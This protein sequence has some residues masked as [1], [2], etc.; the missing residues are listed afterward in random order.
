MIKYIL[1]KLKLLWIYIKVSLFLEFINRNKL[2]QDLLK[3]NYD[4]VENS[5]YW[6]NDLKNEYL[7]S[8]NILKVSNVI[9]VHKLWDNGYIPVLTNGKYDFD[10]IREKYNDEKTLYISDYN[11]SHFLLSDTDQFYFRIA[12]DLDHIE[13]NIGFGWIN[14]FYIYNEL[15]SKAKKI[16]NVMFFEIVMKAMY[17]DYKKQFLDEK[18]E[19]YIDP[20]IITLLSSILRRIL[21]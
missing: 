16:R 21:T 5:N 7:L 3:L 15:H 10:Y 19:M 18:R 2:K 12:H 11:L 13:Q 14:E 4:I 1:I 17:Y 9:I 8:Y 20:F 6:S